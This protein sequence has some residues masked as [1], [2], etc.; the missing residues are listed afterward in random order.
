MVSEEEGTDNFPNATN[1]PGSF[2]A[3]RR[4]DEAFGVYREFIRC[5][6]RTLLLTAADSKNIV[7]WRGTAA[8]PGHVVP[9][10]GFD[11]A[12]CIRA[13]PHRHHLPLC[14]SLGL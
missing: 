4:A 14:R 11:G 13:R 8:E 9:L 2:E 6:P 7:D 12:I 3:G 10:D 5:N 1:A